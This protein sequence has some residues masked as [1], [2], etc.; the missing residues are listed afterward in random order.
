MKFFILQII[1]VR[2]TKL[3]EYTQFLQILQNIEVLV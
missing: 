1:V 3:F 2:Y